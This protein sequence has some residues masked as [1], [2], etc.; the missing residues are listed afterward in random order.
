[1]L[2]YLATLEITSVFL[3]QAHK[4]EGMA[5][6]KKKALSVERDSVNTRQFLNVS[7]EL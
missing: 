1:M 3:L 7:L 6:E 5:A 4:L 2:Q